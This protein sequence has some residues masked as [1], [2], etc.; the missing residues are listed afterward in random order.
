MSTSHTAFAITATHTLESFTYVPGD[1]LCLA[2][3]YPDALA[4][5]TAT[6]EYVTDTLDSGHL[7]GADTL[8][9]LALTIIPETTTVDCG[10]VE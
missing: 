7:P 5:V 1:G 6:L 10:G 8:D 9:Y 4:A 2:A 3:L